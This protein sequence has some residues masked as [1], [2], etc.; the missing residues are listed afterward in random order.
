MEED[1]E[2]AAQEAAKRKQEEL[3]ASLQASAPAP[4]VERS[5]AERREMEAKMSEANRKLMD[6]LNHTPDGKD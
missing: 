1:A 3:F 2:T 4:E 6:L 5:E